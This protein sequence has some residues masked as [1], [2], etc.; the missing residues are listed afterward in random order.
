VQAHADDLRVE[1][2]NDWA[3]LTGE[4]AAPDDAA[5][6]GFVH[7]A[8]RDWR[9]LPLTQTV[10]ALLDYADKITRTPA[11]CNAADVAS[12]RAAGW[13]DAAIHDAVQVVAYFNYINRVAD[14]L[15]VEPEPEPSFGKWGSTT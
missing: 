12:L 13:C 14:A 3:V 11:A 8:V 5:L 7:E 10:T 4:P 6:D 2:G 1:I 9:E 15:G